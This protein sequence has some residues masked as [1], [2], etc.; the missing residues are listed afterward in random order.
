MSLYNAS[1]MQFPAPSS[2]F[3]VSRENLRAAK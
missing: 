1:V 3:H 2:A